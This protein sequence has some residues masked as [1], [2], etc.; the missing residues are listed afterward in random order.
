MLN[1]ALSVTRAAILAILASSVCCHAADVVLIRTVGATSAEQQALE[2]ATEFYGLNLKV[3][4]AT[5]NGTEFRGTVDQNET[6]AV[7]I[8]ANALHLLHKGALLQVLRRRSAGDIPLLILG[9]T[10]ETESILLSDWSD[11]AVLGIQRL[12]SP[13]RL[14]Y[15]VGHVAG[16]TRQLTD[17]EFPFPGNHT[18]YLELADRSKVQQIMAVQ[19]DHQAVP[20]FIEVDLHQQRVFLLPKIDPAQN[21]EADGSTETIETVFAGVAPMMMFVRFC[22]GEHGW[23]TLRHY[24]NLTIDDPWLREPYGDLSYKGLLS[25]MD[26]HNFH[27]TIAFIPWNYDRSESETTSLFRSHPERFSICIHGDNHDHKEFEDLAS[28]PLSVQTVALEQSLARMEEFKK[29]TGLAYDNVFVFPHSIGSDSIL[30]KLKAYNFL[31]TINSSNVPMDRLSPSTPSFALRPITLSFEN[32]ASIRRYSAAMPNPNAFLGINEFLDNPLFFYTHQDFFASGIGAFDGMADDVNKIEPDIEWRSLGNIVEHLY[33]VRE[34]GDSNYDVLAFSNTF[35]LE[36]TVGRN[37]VFEVKKQESSSPQVAS[38]SVDGREYPVQ[39][40]EGYLHLTVPVPAGG[41]RRVVIQYRNVLNLASVGTSKSS[42]RV[43]LLRE[44][45][46]FRD[47][48]LSKY[49]VGRRLTAYYYNRELTP[50]QAIAYG[51]VLVLFLV[52]G[53]WT[54]RAIMKRK[55]AVA[56]IPAMIP[57]KKIATPTRNGGSQC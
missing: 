8:D 20:V 12:T 49:G 44:A 21:R 27:T 15:A 4:T 31:A 32:F 29:L 35:E 53:G 26:K 51:C 14:R 13:T 43:Y 16:V 33:L 24:A 55:S 39:F 28:K 22:A 46:D 25:E 7:A 10:T 38:V 42:L 34:R 11:G 52:C 17:L 3:I 5:A 36:N 54:L 56:R 18:F 1:R 41:G 30:E 48:T 37:V 57:N 45:S 40:V 6:V 19:N 2:L 9:V 50:L 23:H 47:I